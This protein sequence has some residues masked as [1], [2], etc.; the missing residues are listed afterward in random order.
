MFCQF[1]MSQTSPF[2]VAAGPGQL[3][4]LFAEHLSKRVAS[5]CNLW[6]KRLH[7]ISRIASEEP[8]A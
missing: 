7:D 5:M 6:L 4:L 1:F 2:Y 3:R 8:T